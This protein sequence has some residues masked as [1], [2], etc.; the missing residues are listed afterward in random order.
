MPTPLID[1]ICIRAQ[2]KEGKWGSFSLGELVDMERG[3]FA[4]KWLLHK[5]CGY[6]EGTI[7]T[8]ESI[9]R[10]ADLL[11]PGSYVALKDV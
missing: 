5:L 10:L 1:R 8:R 2:D 7:I 3:V 9:S 6:E 11:E 4:Y